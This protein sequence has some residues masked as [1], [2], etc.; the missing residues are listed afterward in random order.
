MDA[1]QG[2]ICAFMDFLS[3]TIL[4]EEDSR[5]AWLE[6]IAVTVLDECRQ[7]GMRTTP[8][9][10]QP[11]HYDD[12]DDDDQ[13]WL[14]LPLVVRNISMLQRDEDMV[15]E[16]LMRARL[17]TIMAI[18]ALQ[19][20]LGVNDA[21]W[22][23]HVQDILS[24]RDEADLATK[25]MTS[26]RWKALASTVTGFLTIPMLQDDILR[27]G[28]RLLATVETICL[29]FITGIRMDG[30]ARQDEF[31]ARIGSSSTQNSNSQDQDVSNED[32]ALLLH[33]I[34]CFDN[35]SRSL[36]KYASKFST[37]PLFS[38][39]EHHLSCLHDFSASYIKGIGSAT[40]LTF[41]VQKRIDQM[42]GVSQSTNATTASN[43][44]PGSD[45]DK[46]NEI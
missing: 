20:C 8:S 43:N 9:S 42:F 27:N 39:V 6:T 30:K 5:N 2:V 28:Q 23:A 35:E 15:V 22:D 29:C 25:S 7:F 24:K 17:R 38:R 4:S 12:D 19:M 13:F 26:F 11:H 34:A 33:V 31:V 21:E 18:R 44:S 10:Q 41:R 37:D 16:D 46:D 1:L 45:D 14:C 36:G 32:E 40:P 3:R